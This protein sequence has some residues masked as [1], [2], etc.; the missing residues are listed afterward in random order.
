MPTHQSCQPN[1]AAQSERLQTTT[2]VILWVPH[3]RA[4]WLWALTITKTSLSS[5]KLLI[6][7]TNFQSW[8]DRTKELFDAW[9]TW[10]KSCTPTCHWLLKMLLPISD[11]IQTLSK[12][13][14]L[15]WCHPPIKPCCLLAVLCEQ[16]PV[17]QVLINQFYTDESCPLHL[18]YAEFVHSRGEDWQRISIAQGLISMHKAKPWDEKNAFASG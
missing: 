10:K 17:S 6:L 18:W 2:W 16:N 12:W 15:R 8:S 11:S 5:W 3:G 7:N 13:N 9:G 14:A 4:E 1:N